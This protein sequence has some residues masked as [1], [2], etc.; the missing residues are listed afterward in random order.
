MGYISK[1]FLIMLS[2]LSIV[3][4]YA[5]AADQ[6]HGISMGHSTRVIFHSDERRISFPIKNEENYNMIFHALVLN[7]ERDSFSNYFIASPELIHLK[8]QSTETAQIVRIGG[9][10]PEDRESLFVLQGHFLPAQKNGESESSEMTLSY[11]MQMKMFYRPAKL[12]ASFDAIDD[13]SDQ[14]DFDVDGKSL[15]IK[16]KSPYFITLNYLETDK[17]VVPI[18]DNRSMIDP[19]GQVSLDLKNFD[20]KQIRWS[21]LN[22]GGYATKVLTRKL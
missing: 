11:V 9:K 7:R 2:C 1:G 17:E 4:N 5:I 20:I 14:L 12:R 18:P 22:D 16:N 15:T 3:C 13:V 10:F 6:G 8:K 19:F 21:L